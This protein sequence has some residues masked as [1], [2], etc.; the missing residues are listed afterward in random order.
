MFPLPEHRNLFFFVGYC[1]KIV[2]VKMLKALAIIDGLGE[3]FSPPLPTP[4]T[5]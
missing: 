1:P 5:L 4:P 2:P 3:T